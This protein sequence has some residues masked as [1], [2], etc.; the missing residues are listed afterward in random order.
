MKKKKAFVIQEG[1]YIQLLE[2]MYLVLM[3][4]VAVQSNELVG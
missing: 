4:L 1:K 3:Y 2:Q